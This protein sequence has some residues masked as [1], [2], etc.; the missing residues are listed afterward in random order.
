MEEARFRVIFDGALTGEFEQED[1]Q[2]RF[3]KLF[4]ITPQKAAAFFGGKPRVLKSDLDEE[5]AMSY[6]F[7]LAEA[8]CECAIEEI[9]E[10]P[11]EG[12]EERRSSGERRVRF[13]RPPR[14]G[15]IQPDR[16]VKIRRVVDRRLLLKLHKRGDQLPLALQPYPISAA[17][18]D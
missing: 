11:P 14:P 16:R 18:A 6:M 17:E 3:A 1:A 8:G 5:T 4:R 2:K 10:G 13:R 9:V 7:K 15:A 12:I